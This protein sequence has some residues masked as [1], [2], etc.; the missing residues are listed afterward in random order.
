MDPEARQRQVL[1]MIKRLTHAQ[2]ARQPGVQVF[3]D[4]HWLDPATEAFL[5]NQVEVS[6]GTRSL[7]V[8]NYRPG[9]HAP[10]M[11]KSF[12]RQVALTPLSDDAIAEMLEDLLGSHESLAGLGD[13][14][15]E[16]TGGNPFFLEEVVQSLVEAGNLQGEPGS[17][18]LVRPVEDAAVPANVQAVLSARIDRLP[19]RAKEVLQTAAV[20][21]KEFS[22]PVLAS[23]IDGEATE[24]ADALQAL[25][26]GE[27]IYEQE[28]YPEAV[29]AFKHPL[30]QEVAYG[31]QLGDRRAAVHAAVAQSLAEQRS[32]RLDENAAILAQHWEAAGE[33]LEAARWHARAATWS[34]F[35][36]PTASLRHWR[37]V[38]ELADSLPAS[39]E[40]QSLGL[41]ARILSLQYGWRLGITAE[42]AE[43]L[44]QEAERMASAVGDLWSRANL[45]VAYGSIRC[46]GDGDSE[47]YVKLAREGIALAE[48]TSDPALH[49]TVAFGTYA[50][51]IAGEFR[52]V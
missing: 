47:A 37:R 34:G 31:S 27:F 42:E 48:E 32:E 21:G 8:L 7:M 18:E 11:S 1:G 26:A 25:V 13:Q 33:S 40:V 6:Q 52:E 16:R 10:W 2:S 15:R 38:R 24:L 12:Y 51:N 17:Y 50:F 30:T 43:A 9:Y 29:Y 35:S 49:M 28:L 46:M 39:D 23:V 3:E 19:Q 45:L 41:T 22:E 14:I 44:F 5:A 4:L 36:D 20:I